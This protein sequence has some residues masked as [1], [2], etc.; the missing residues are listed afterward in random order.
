MRPWST[1]GY[2][3]P[4]IAADRLSKL[5]VELLLAD[6]PRLRAQDDLHR[7]T[8]QGE[9]SYMQAY[10]LIKTATENEELADM[11]AAQYV[12]DQTRNQENP[13]ETEMVM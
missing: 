2:F 4:G 13:S 1:A 6:Y 11:T 9:L 8:T 10:D 7:R 3:F 5:Q 12:L